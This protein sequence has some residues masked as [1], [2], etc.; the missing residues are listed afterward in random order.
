MRGLVGGVLLLAGLI[1]LLVG[2]VGLVR[3]RVTVAGLAS[4]REAG[5]AVGTALAILLV[6]GA[7][8][9][10]EGAPS[11]TLAVAQVREQQPDPELAASAPTAA[12]PASAGPAPADRPPAADPVLPLPA[13]AQEAV[14][15]RH[16]DGDTLALRGLAVGPVL[17]STSQI[18]VRL[19]EI[20]TPE[21]K[22]PGTPVQCYGPEAS[23]RLA[24]LAPVGTRVYVV[25]DRERTDQYGRDLLYLWDAQGASINLSLVDGGFAK[26]V[27]YAPNDR[28][29]TVLRA[30]ESA[31]KTAGRGLWGA[32]P[33]PAAAPAPA[34]AVTRRAPAPVVPAPAAAR[35]NCDPAYPSVCI[36]PPLPDLD[37]GEIPH[38]RFAVLAPDPHGFDGNSDGVGCESG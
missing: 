23:A 32:C 15:D 24:A 33:G 1:L 2:I 9:P 6:G 13:E 14:V 17:S 29:I 31:A 10:Q 16:I 25:A 34:S 4:R 30:A 5:I 8:S 20:D 28:Y 27:L 37:C 21:T 35:G 7:I 19:L 11:D 36:P 22:Q 18:T 26:A 12:S 38:R 3:G